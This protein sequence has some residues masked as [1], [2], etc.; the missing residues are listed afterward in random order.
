MP[1]PVSPRIPLL[2]RSGKLR[3]AQKASSCLIRTPSL[4]PD[5]LTMRER[6]IA[7]KS[8]PPEFQENLEK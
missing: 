1:S 3:P 5:R 7:T 8:V 6:T 4:D 2:D